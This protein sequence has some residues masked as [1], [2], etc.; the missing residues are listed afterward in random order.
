MNT[1]TTSQ[2][3]AVSFIRKNG[4]EII[5]RDICGHID[6]VTWD[7]KTDEIVFIEVIERKTTPKARR[8]NWKITYHQ[9]KAIRD[10]LRVNKWRGKH[11]F[12]VIEIYGTDKPV[13]D[14]IQNVNLEK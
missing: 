3:H 11:R 6:I 12:D 1:F 8:R 4:M 7:C 2:Q 9:R 14:R 10:W 5:D 13:I